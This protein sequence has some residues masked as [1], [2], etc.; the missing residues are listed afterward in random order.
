V[1]EEQW[2]LTT[3]STNTTTTI[4]IHNSTFYC[5]WSSSLIVMTMLSILGALIRKG[6]KWLDYLSKSY[7]SVNDAFLYS[8]LK[9]VR[10]IES[11]DWCVSREPV[12]LALVQGIKLWTK[13]SPVLEIDKNICC[14]GTV[15][16]WSWR[17]QFLWFE[18]SKWSE[19]EKI[20]LWWGPGLTM[21]EE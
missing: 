2:Y 12:W 5:T 10:K 7:I 8:G 17:V 9:W 15:T 19:R 16:K 1:L 3:G 6:A 21:E 18:F 11:Q 14:K 13:S 20:T 4:I